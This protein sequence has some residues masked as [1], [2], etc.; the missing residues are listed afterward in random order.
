[1]GVLGE[2]SDVEKN[3]V[4]AIIMIARKRDETPEKVYQ[5]HL[6]IFLKTE[7][8]AL[9][10]RI[11]KAKGASQKEMMEIHCGVNDFIM[12]SFKEIREVNKYAKVFDSDF[13]GFEIPW[14]CGKTEIH[15][16]EDI[17]AA[18][19]FLKNSEGIKRCLRVS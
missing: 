7:K 15:A 19:D 10:A 2:M 3:Y 9:N 14:D 16:L 13:S 18:R 11:I 12:Q 5:E 6:A 17:Y 1:M 8:E 4:A